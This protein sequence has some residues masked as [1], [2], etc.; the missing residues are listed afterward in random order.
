MAVRS[1]WAR[2]MTV[3]DLWAQ[4]YLKAV[5]D[6]EGEWP[7]PGPPRPRSILWAFTDARDAAQAFRLA[8]ESEGIE[9]EVLLIGG[10]DTCSTV[11]TR[12]LISRHYP[13]VPLKA[14]LEGHAS[15]FSNEK[16]S[17]MLGYRPRYTWRASDFRDWMDSQ[18]G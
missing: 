10:N 9:H 14:P 7:V 11:E 15:L 18:T 16:A 6:S 13:G 5:E 8:V 12:E 4:R 3:E 2:G 17:R 1:G